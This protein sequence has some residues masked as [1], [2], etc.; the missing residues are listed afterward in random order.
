MGNEDRRDGRLVRGQ[1]TRE[2]VLDAA[3]ALASVHGL[4]GLSFGQLAGH[5][6]ASK[7]GLFAHWKDKEQL[8]LDAIDWARKQWTKRVMAPALRT[9][10][11]LRRVFALHEARLAFYADGVLPGGCFFLAAQTEFDD[12][13]G[14]VHARTAESLHDWL[15]FIRSLI[16]EA[17]ALGELPG[18]LDIGQLTY[19]ID[20]LGES[21]VVHS[22]FVGHEVT[23]ARARH[24]VLERL[25]ALATDPAVLP[26]D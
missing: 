7:S 22:R 17:V 14:A 24:A 4:E 3:V 11:G 20:A 5:L 18:D 12:R 26:E 15:E 16:D 10:P 21:T 9:P 1:R 19:E 2:T 23:F 25:R 13:T 8:Q 6:G